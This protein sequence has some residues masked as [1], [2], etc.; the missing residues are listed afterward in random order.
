MSILFV[1]ARVEKPDPPVLIVI[2]V[3]YNNRCIRD[4][5]SS[6]K[7]KR[8]D[9]YTPYVHVHLCFMLSCMSEMCVTRDRDDLMMMMSRECA[10]DKVQLQRVHPH[11]QCCHMT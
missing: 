3:A 5:L 1:D 10:E 7:L 6:N 2:D 8:F 9:T 4:F 11:A